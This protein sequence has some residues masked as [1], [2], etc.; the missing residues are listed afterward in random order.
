MRA[1][2]TSSMVG[3]FFLPPG[4]EYAA[5]SVEPEDCPLVLE[6]AQVLL[7]ARQE[8]E[9]NASTHATTPDGPEAVRLVGRWPRCGV[10]ALSSH[11]ERSDSPA[12]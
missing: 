8:N 5:S 9:H 3:S 11:D 7:A 10:R 1:P 6:A 2:R 12:R 4:L